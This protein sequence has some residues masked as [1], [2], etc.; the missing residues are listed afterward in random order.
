MQLPCSTSITSINNYL[1]YQYYHAVAYIT[2]TLWLIPAL[3]LATVVNDVIMMYSKERNIQFSLVAICW[4]CRPMYLLT[5]DLL[6]PMAI[7]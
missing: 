5:Y 1:N 2:P 3:I 6:T 4:S 7:D